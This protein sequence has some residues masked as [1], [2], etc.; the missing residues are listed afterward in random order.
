WGRVGVRAAALRCGG[1]VAGGRGG[2]TAGL[3]GGLPATM[4][5]SLAV[6]TTA[7]RGDAPVYGVNTG[8]GALADTRVAERDMAQLQAAIIVSHAAAAGDPLDDATVRALLLLRARTLAAGVWGARA[9]R[10]AG[11]IERLPLHG[12]PAAPGRGSVGASGDLPQLAH[13]AQPLIGGGRLRAPGDPPRGRPAGEV[14]AE[15]GIEPLEFAPK[16]G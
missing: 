6:V 13:R 5:P 11:R 15:H 2:G 1:G 3:A 14:L 10:P 8:F 4:E 7:I 12:V 9:A 16:E